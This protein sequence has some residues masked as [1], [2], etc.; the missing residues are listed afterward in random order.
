[1]NIEKEREAFEEAWLLQHELKYF[2]FDPK[3]R[4]YFLK[5]SVA[6]TLDAEE[7][8][9]TINSGWSMWLKAKAHEAKK[10]EGCVVVPVNNTTIVAVEKMVEQQVEASGIT[11]DVF[12]LDGEKIL[13]AAVE[14]ARGGK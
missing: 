8:Y 4:Q 6:G 3:D 14:A 13:Y 9:H 12:R 1:M 11:A 2:E 10:L 7:A 5:D